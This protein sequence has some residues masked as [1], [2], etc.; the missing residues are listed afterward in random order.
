MNNLAATFLE[1]ALLNYEKL[2]LELL[3][4]AW[5]NLDFFWAISLI[6]TGLIGVL[7]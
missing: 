3:R 6:A 7:V 4:K 5:F 2:G 1:V